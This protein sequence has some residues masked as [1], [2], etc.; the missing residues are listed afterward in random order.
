MWWDRLNYNGELRE[1]AVKIERC[2]VERGNIMVVR[3]TMWPLLMP[4]LLSCLIASST[5]SH[6][7]L[8]RYIT[9]IVSLVPNAPISPPLFS[10]LQQQISLCDTTISFWSHSLFIKSFLYLLGTVMVSNVFTP[11]TGEFPCN[12]SLWPPFYHLVQQHISLSLH[13]ALT[14]T[15]IVFT[16]SSAEFSVYLHAYF[17]ETS[18]V[19]TLSTADFALFATLLFHAQLEHVY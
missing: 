12:L 9:W 5:H 6:L 16:G 3:V 11:S 15:S 7:R 17:K 18:I 10:V 1:R 19:S 14:Q 8:Q 13:R 4:Y 2:A